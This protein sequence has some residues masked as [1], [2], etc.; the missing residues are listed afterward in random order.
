M[1]INNIVI[2]YNP[3]SKNLSHPADR[4]RFIFFATY[5]NIKFEIADYNKKYDY[6]ILTGL[7]DFTLWKNYNKGKIIF[8]LLD[9]YLFENSSYLKNFSEKFWK[10]FVKTI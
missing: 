4:R 10:I 7:S 5:K 6:V 9:P 8:E 1:R 2:G 3:L